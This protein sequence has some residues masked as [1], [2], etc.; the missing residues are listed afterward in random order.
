MSSELE[1]VVAVLVV[2]VAVVSQSHVSIATGHIAS[3]TRYEIRVL[4]E[5]EECRSVTV[6]AL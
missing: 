3:G 4:V 5:R 2:G 1:M 6:A